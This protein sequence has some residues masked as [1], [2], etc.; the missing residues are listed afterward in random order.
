MYNAGMTLVDLPL[1]RITASEFDQ[2]IDAGVFANR[3]VELIEGRI[4]EMTPQG[5]PHWVACHLT[6]KRLERAFG[7]GFVVRAAGSLRLADHSQP[8]P[9]LLVLAGDP[10]D[11]LTQGRPT[12]GLL[13]VEVSAT[14]LRTDRTVMARL[15]ASAAIPEYWIVNL[16]DRQIEVHRDPD[17]AGN[18][19]PTYRNR[20]VHSP[21][22]PITP[23]A[24]PTASIDPADILP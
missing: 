9:D 14:S 17:P 6:Q 13:V 22:H 11:R 10:R 21:G 18:P 12:T 23:L 2:M 7:N 19:H 24:A 1:A 8:E 15:Y 16:I 3:R 4:V 20:T 5:E